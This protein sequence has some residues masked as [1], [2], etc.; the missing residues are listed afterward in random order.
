MELGDPLGGVPV[1]EVADISF[2]RQPACRV[3]AGV[4]RGQGCSRIHCLLQHRGD[5]APRDVVAFGGRRG[6]VDGPSFGDLRQG[7]KMLPGEGPHAGDLCGGG[8]SAS[9][10]SIQCLR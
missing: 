8:T 9:R 5:L 7:S 10:E 4:C 1:G 6:Q 3:Q 2:E